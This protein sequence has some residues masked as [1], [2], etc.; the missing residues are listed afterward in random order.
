MTFRSHN[1]AFSGNNISVR[2]ILTLFVLASIAFA[3]DY[4]D[5]RLQADAAAAK[6]DYPAAR[7]FLSKAID[8]RIAADGR[9]APQ[10]LPDYLSLALLYKVGDQQKEGLRVLDRASEIV[11]RGT[12][13]DTLALADV[14]STRAVLLMAMKETLGAISVLNTAITLRES[15][16][17]ANHGALVPDLD[18][19]A[20]VCVV[21]RDYECA[22]S[23]ARRAVRIRE[24]LLGPEDPDLLSMLDVLAYALYGQKKYEDAEGVYLRLVSLWEA[25]AGSHNPMLALTLEK[26]AVFYRSWEK[27]EKADEAAARALALRVHFHASGLV[28]R[29]GEEL[30][31]SRP[32]DALKL[33]RQALALLTP[34]H[35]ALAELRSQIQEQIKLIQAA[36]RPVTSKKGR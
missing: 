2:S 11:L 28:K 21:R 3:D 24:R 26:I 16:V 20:S 10:L 15:I 35:P 5:L 18:R 19:L 34:D 23:A 1:A 17:G 8:A 31:A 13:V 6:R 25:S 14:H 32:V 33:Y 22:E 29:A 9:F 4:S 12:P 30:A 36:L 7:D 27:P